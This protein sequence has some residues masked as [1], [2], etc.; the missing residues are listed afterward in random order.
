MCSSVTSCSDN[1]QTKDIPISN[2]DTILSDKNIT[3]EIDLAVSETKTKAAEYTSQMR[4]NIWESV[5]MEY[6]RFQTPE[7]FIAETDY[8]IKAV[9]EFVSKENWFDV[10]NRKSNICHIEYLLTNGISYV[11][12]EEKNGYQVYV[13]LKKDF[14][15]HDLAPIVNV[16]TNIIVPFNNNS[17]LSL[18]GGLSSYCQDK[19]GKNPSVHN[20]GIDVHTLANLFLN[21]SPELFDKVFPVIGTKNARQNEYADGDLRQLFCVL[22]YSF[23]KY[24]IDNFGIDCFMNLYESKNLIS[25]YNTFY[26]KSFDDIKLEWHSFVESYPGMTAEEYINYITELLTKHNYPIE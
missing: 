22:S 10:Y 17:S 4:D 1:S 19:F 12:V 7:E 3:E 25:D 8:Y 13:Y 6:G 9:S 18:I 23:S 26:G 16:I 14:F 24:L 11:E 20:Y 21:Y 5:N 15:E 2:T